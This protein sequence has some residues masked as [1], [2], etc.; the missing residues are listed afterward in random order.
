MV[1]PGATALTRIPW[2]PSSCANARVSAASAAF[3]ALY[4]DS[5]DS[6][7]NALAL[8]TFTITPG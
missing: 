3:E 6:F 2:C 7:W 4:T 8:T 5:G 1:S